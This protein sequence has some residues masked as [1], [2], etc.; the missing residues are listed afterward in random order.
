VHQV[1]EAFGFVCCWAAHYGNRLFCSCG[2][3]SVVAW[4]R[5]SPPR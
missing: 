5:G 3:G 1:S 2:V 4:R